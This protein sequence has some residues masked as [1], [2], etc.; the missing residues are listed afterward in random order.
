MDVAQVEL[1]GGDL[2]AAERDVRAD[3]EFLENAKENYFRSTVAALL[4][5]LVRDQGRGTEALELTRVAE[6]AT[7]EQ[8][9]V[10]QTMWRCVRAP[11]LAEQGDLI[12]GEALARAAVDLAFK[13]ECVNVQADALVEYGAV[14]RF[15]NRNEE[16]AEAL[17]R[18]CALYESKGNRAAL[19]QCQSRRSTQ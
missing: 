18:A 2:A 6:A 7:S 8:D 4:A 9:V 10:S 16:A 3:Y 13:T 12:G 19:A 15:A 14:L 11:I 5:H 1:L 17:A